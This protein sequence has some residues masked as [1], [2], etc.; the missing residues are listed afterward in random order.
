MR[1]HRTKPAEPTTYHCTSRLVAEVP[2]L[3]HDEKRVL[4][5]R[6][7]KLTR[8]CRMLLITFTL[9]GNHYHVLARSPK[10]K[11]LSDA[12]L[13]KSLRQFYGPR[14]PQVEE[15]LE[16]LQSDPPLL[17]QL[18]ARYLAR[19]GDV[20]VFNKEL[21]EGFTRWY[22]RRHDREGTLWSKR[23]DSVIVGPTL[24]DL[25]VVS[26]YIDLNALR[27]RLVADPKDYPFGGYAEALAGDREARAGL[28]TFLPPGRWQERLAHYRMVLYGTGGS[29]RQPG[30]AVLKPEVIAKVMKQKGQLSLAQVLRVRVRYFTNGVVVGSEEYVEKIWRKYCK[31]R[32]SKRKTGARKMKGAEWGEMRVMRDLQKDVLG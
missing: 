25:M 14:S 11:T 7:R 5:A 13:L 12:Q 6:L 8:F 9:M 26:A 31:R 27:A 4:R 21:K 20:S 15:F 24:R 23:F 3:T 17:A 1:L 2:F 29:T 30:K 32:G 22:N 10:K 19:M 16:A 28:G 18:R